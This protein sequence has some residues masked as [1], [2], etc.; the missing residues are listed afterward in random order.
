MGQEKPDSSAN[1][2]LDNTADVFEPAEH[3]AGV[4]EPAE[5]GVGVVAQDQTVDAAGEAMVTENDPEGLG[6]SDNE[7]DPDVPVDADND[8]DIVMDSMMPGE[9][10]RFPELQV[11]GVI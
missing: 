9:D 5:D 3:G 10:E 11:Q 1:S 6:H 8:G 7:D 4:V 2:S